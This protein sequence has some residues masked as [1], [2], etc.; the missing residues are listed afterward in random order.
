MSATADI[1]CIY[2]FKVAGRLKLRKCV[3]SR[4]VCFYSSFEPT[5]VIVEEC[6]SLYSSVREVSVCDVICDVIRVIPVRIPPIRLSDRWTPVCAALSHATQT[7]TA[8]TTF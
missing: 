7:G 8:V 3:D 4:T 5:H 6:V 1:R 2:I